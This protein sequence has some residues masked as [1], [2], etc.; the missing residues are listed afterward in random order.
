MDLLPWS[1]T[2]ARI[3]VAV[4]LMVAGAHK[5]RDVAG[6]KETLAAYAWLPSSLRSPMA[7]LLPVCEVVLGLVLL[8]GFELGLVAGLTAVLFAFFAIAFAVNFGRYGSSD[9][10]C[11]GR[12]AEASTS[13]VLLRNASLVF[14]SLVAMSAGILDGIEGA[15]II[16][17]LAVVVSLVTAASTLLLGVPPLATNSEDVANSSRRRFLRLTAG[18]VT[19]LGVAALVGIGRRPRAA[20][21]ACHGCGSCGTDYIFLNC[22][23]TCCASYIVQKFN[24]CDTYCFFCSTSSRIYCGVLECC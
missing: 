9:C 1:E 24:D 4:V 14:L 22:V 17:A 23:G 5:L 7:A 21:A 11:F 13:S 10:G 16:L 18:A 19:G 6:F 20:E 3:A 8:T 12:G 2:V 15:G